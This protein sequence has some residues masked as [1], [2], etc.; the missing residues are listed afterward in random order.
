MKL[1]IRA[2]IY[3]SVVAILST[4]SPLVVIASPSEGQESQAG[5]TT[6]GTSDKGEATME[7]TVSD[8]HP[9][10]L[11]G[12][13]S[14][15]S[16]GSEGKAAGASVDGSSHE[17]GATESG[18]S[19]GSIEGRSEGSL[20]EGPMGGVERTILG[21]NAGQ[22]GVGIEGTGQEGQLTEGLGGEGHGG[23][24]NEGGNGEG[25]GSDFQTETQTLNDLY[26]FSLLIDKI[27]KLSLQN[28]SD[29]T[30]QFIFGTGK[31]LGLNSFNVKDTADSLGISVTD[32]G[33]D[34]I[35]Q[36]LS[37]LSGKAYDDYLVQALSDSA[38]ALTAET[39]GSLNAFPGPG[40]QNQRFTVN[41]FLNTLQTGD[42]ILIALRDHQPLSGSLL[43]N[44]ETGFALDPLFNLD[45]YIQF[46]NDG[47][48]TKAQSS[49][50]RLL[51]AQ[52]AS[53]A[54]QLDTQLQ[55]AAQSLGATLSAAE[56][57]ELEQ[58]L[59]T[60]SGSAYDQSFVAGVPAFY[61]STVT[62]VRIVLPLVPAATQDFLNKVIKA[63]EA[64]RQKVLSL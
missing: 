2:L 56:E 54:Q 28:S 36:K 29:P 61:E 62:S 50:L 16:H 55:A 44:L 20:A 46:I 30:I 12:G 21:G 39:Q 25:K 58:R 63:L 35:Y 48:Q 40:T 32:R 34:A 11:E 64:D 49:A 1:F 38:G 42:Q 14:G 19:E 27:A 4:Y 37:T 60:L 18:M 26:N 3:T 59:V 41:R 45:H 47:A 33:N 15:G 7:G 5:G 22:V 10:S 9:A 57:N 8:T 43:K 52:L 53:D 31:Y 51:S 24:G 17:G 13:V 23:S 6:R